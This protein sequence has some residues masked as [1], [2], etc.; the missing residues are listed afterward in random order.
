MFKIVKWISMDR[1]KL[2][3]ESWVFSDHVVHF[4][5]LVMAATHSRQACLPRLN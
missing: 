3:K 1:K 5:K 2:A 4:P